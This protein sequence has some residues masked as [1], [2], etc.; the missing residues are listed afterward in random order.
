MASR[1]STTVTQTVLLGSGVY[2]SPLTVTASGTIAPVAPG[3]DGVYGVEAGVVLINRGA[4]SGAA[5]Y[6]GTGGTGVDLAQGGTIRNSGS[7]TGGQGQDGAIG[8]GGI[9]VAL[10]GGELDNSGTI[11]G[12]RGYA[13][14]YHL[15]N[16]GIGVDVIG[17][18]IVHNTGAIYG[19]DAGSVFTGSLSVA[20]AGIYLGAGSVLRNSGTIGGG[21]AGSSYSDPGFS[22][23]AAGMGAEIA[24]GGTVV[25]AG[26]I[27]GGTGAADLNEPGAAGLYL[28][29]GG[30]LT[31]TGT[32]AGGFGGN[33]G[34]RS[35]PAA[36]GVGVKAEDSILTNGGTIEGGVGGNSGFASPTGGAGGAAIDLIDS[37]LSNTGHIVGGAGGL[38]PG[39]ENGGAVGGD[40]VILEIA[41]SI[42]NTG[43]ISGGAGVGRYGYDQYGRAPGVFGGT[44]VLLGSTGTLE[45][46]GA[47]YGGAAVTTDVASIDPGG[48]GVDVTSF[49]TVTNAGL[50]A[51]GAG[52]AGYE[53]GSGGVGVDLAGGGLLQ[54]KGTI[55]G[56]EGGPASG[57]P[58]FAYG[59]TGGTGVFVNGGTLENA[60]VISGGAPGG[61][62]GSPGL[63]GEAVQ[64]GS[65]TATLVIDPGAVF[66]G[67]VAGVLAAT[68]R[69]ELATSAHTGTLSGLGTQFTGFRLLGEEAGGRWLLTGSNTLAAQT[70][71]FGSGL[72]TVTGSLEDAGQAILGTSGTLS[73]AGG[74][75]LALG[76]AALSGGTLVTD[77]ASKLIIG[78]SQAD[79][80]D[81]AVVIDAGAVVGGHGSIG[82][83]GTDAIVDNGLIAAYGGTTDLAA[84]TTG[85][86]TVQ[87]GAGG[88]LSVH[89]S[90]SA[91]SVE[92]LA[93]AGEV[94]RMAANATVSSP[95]SGFRAGDIIDIAKPATSLSFIGQ[96]LTLEYGAHSVA[97]LTLEGSY[98]AADFVL[99][100]DG[101]GGTDIGFAAADR[102]ALSPA[103]PAGWHDLAKEAIGAVTAALLS[104]GHAS[105]WTF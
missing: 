15:G 51:G 45:N 78:A 47:I 61:G 34:M 33:D 3:S 100:S 49:G 98:S 11:K 27:F 12:G 35:G 104:H 75:T 39:V 74:G 93:G 88:T 16:G 24:P 44:G 32:I 63:Q 60:G 37:T 14:P 4:I 66:N 69:L 30:V 102:P 87:I 55:R 58:N 22:G 19:G 13:N 50:I 31:N 105:P 77:S 25:N 72:L 40:G 59:G 95:I 42:S 81:G 41:G 1:I 29:S 5:T 52:Q 6:Y 7:I 10:A 71:F 103:D 97:T 101:H 53:G 89:S 21:A 57:M 80:Q 67:A 96:T 86:G 2:P 46:R 64:F 79:A 18:A 9:G 28:K 84:A 54:N 43:T 17:S 56:G 62:A 90:F 8:S 70:V 92:F 65:I 91:G 83:N 99:G 36:G 23:Q 85:T 38:P 94:L 68:D 48:T 73:A 82:G 26:L 76:N 20:G